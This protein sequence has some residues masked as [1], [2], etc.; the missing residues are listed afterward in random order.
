MYKGGQKEVIAPPPTQ[1]KLLERAIF[2][3]CTLYHKEGAGAC[4]PWIN[5]LDLSLLCASSQDSCIIKTEKI[6]MVICLSNFLFFFSSP[7]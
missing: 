1:Q 3:W 6:E 2:L 4:S 7:D 5:L